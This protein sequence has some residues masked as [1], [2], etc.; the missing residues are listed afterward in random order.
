MPQQ[1]LFELQPPAWE[2][3]DADDQ[4]V[5]SVVFATGPEQAFD[6]TVPERL[7]E[8]IEVGRRV[9]VPLG[10]GD[11]LVTGYLVGLETRPVVGR[12]LKPLA[13]LVD[14]RSLLSPA[15]L[16]LT[17]WMSGYYLCPWG[18]VLEAVVPA[19]VRWQAGTRE[20]VF[21]RLAPSL[22][23]HFGKGQDKQP[24]EL[25]L[26]PKQREILEL[27]AAAG[28]PLAPT[29]IAGRVGCTLAP[30]N[31][32]RK[33]GLLIAETQRVDSGP[34]VERSER[35]QAHLTLNPDQEVALATIRAA[36]EARWHET[37]L[38]HGVTG[39]GKTEIYIQAIQ[40]VLN[41]GRQAI[42]LVP[43]ISLTPQT[44]QRFRSRFGQVAVLHSHQSDAQRHKHW[45]RIAAGE[46][47][48][49]VGARIAD[50]R[51]HSAAGAGRARRRAR[52]LVQA[53]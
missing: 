14:Q 31:A 36:L 7:R 40:E 25:K 9:R 17:Q 29:A 42:V 44:E 24:G 37:I 6:Y 32:L 10:R 39:S 52:S 41:Y 23:G 28:K 30:I 4:L 49:I 47:R 18:Q 50:F 21:V 5:A 11:R 8:A 2:Q 19:G 43:E 1:S 26:S 27:V 13:G 15:M 51:P 45:Q 35:Q 20:A 22:A 16:R 12:K 34:S 38:V 3:D 46:V 33:R 48:V 53:G